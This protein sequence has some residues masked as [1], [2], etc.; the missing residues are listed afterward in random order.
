MKG[1]LSR[2]MSG[3][4]HQVRGEDRSVTGSRHVSGSRSGAGLMRRRRPRHPALWSSGNRASGDTPLVFPKLNPVLQARRRTSQLSGRSCFIDSRRVSRS[5]LSLFTGAELPCI[6]YDRLLGEEP[7]D[8]G[9][10]LFPL[11]DLDRISGRYAGGPFNSKPRPPSQFM[12]PRACADKASGVSTEASAWTP[13]IDG[14]RAARPPSCFKRIENEFLMCTVS[15]AQ[16]EP[17]ADPRV[18][19]P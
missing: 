12:S 16:R 11:R 1:P 17:H 4:R 9:R 19:L 18:A 6:P 8:G 15:L 13:L 10:R 3:R 5:P 14:P 2:P 7:N